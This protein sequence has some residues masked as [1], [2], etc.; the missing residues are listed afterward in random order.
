MQPQPAQILEDARFRLA[1][2]SLDVGVLDAEDERAVVSVREQ[3][4][5]ECRTRVAH[6]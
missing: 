6:M 2:G 4:V 1:R 5:E 3:P